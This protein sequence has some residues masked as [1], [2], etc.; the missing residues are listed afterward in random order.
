MFNVL[1]KLKLER[2]NVVYKRGLEREKY[3]LTNQI[4]KKN[5][6]VMK[7]LLVNSILKVESTPIRDQSRF[8]LNSY[9]TK[10]FKKVTYIIYKI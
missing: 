9:N 8:W 2:F 6:W 1:E 5:R 10:D 7:Q 4:A 3:E